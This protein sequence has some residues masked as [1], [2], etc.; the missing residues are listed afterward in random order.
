MAMC[1]SKHLFGVIHSFIVC[2]LV[3]D[4]LYF[5]VYLYRPPINSGLYALTPPA[6][7]NSRNAMVAY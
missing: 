7:I 3:C 4:S 2:F 1:R 6:F 5:V